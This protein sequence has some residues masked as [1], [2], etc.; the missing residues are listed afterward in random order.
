MDA[1]KREA[2]RSKYL[3]L[4]AG[5]LVAAAVFAAAALFFVTPRLPQVQDR[6]ALWSALVPLL[7]VLV[8]AGLYWLLARTWVERIAPPRGLAITYRALRIAF[9][10]LLTGGLVGVVIWWPN[11]AGIAALVA[12]VWVFGAVEY[13]NYFVVRLAYPASQWFA[14]V[15]EWRT[16]RLVTDMHSSRHS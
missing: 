3:S 11:N 4:G 14:A 13:A 7:V 9:L 1:G 2:R 6:A 16:P 12:A 8:A 5:E 15:G 10:V